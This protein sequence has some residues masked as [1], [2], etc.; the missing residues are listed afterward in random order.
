MAQELSD[1]IRAAAQAKGID[2]EVALRIASAESAM[3]A[4][5]QAGKSTAGGL[6]QVVDKTWKEFGGAPGK[7]YDAD[8]NIRVGTDI[9]AK[10]TQ[11]LKSFLQ[12]DPRPAEVYA[13]HYFGPTGAKNFLS[14]QPGTP[15]A[16][17]FSKEVIL[18]NPNLKGK[19]TDQVMAS[20]E[21]KMG[22]SPAP[23]AAPVVSRE[24][25]AEQT[26]AEKIMEPALRSGMSAQAPVT[27]DKMAGL[28]AGY[29]AALA[30]SFLA[31]T[32]EKEDRDIDREPG[33]AEKWLAEQPAPSTALADI[34]S[35]SIRS[36]FAAEP[37][38]QMLAEG[39]EAKSLMQRLIEGNREMQ[40]Y[41]RIPSTPMGAGLT[42][43]Y[44]TYKYVTGKDPLQDLQDQLSKRE[45]REI[46][47]GSEPMNQERKRE[48]L[49]PFGRADGG[50]VAHLALGG[51]PYVPTALPRPSVKKELEDI[52]SQ[53]D[54]YNTQAE[55]YN[56][57]LTKYQTE[58]MA[59]YNTQADLYNTGLTKYQTEVVAPYNAQ[60]EA[61][62]RAAEAYN[63]GPRTSEFTMAMPT[64]PA[65]Y[66]M[67]APITPADYSMAAPTAP[68]VSAADYE[69]KGLAARKDVSNRNL[70]L[71]VMADPEQ[72][73]LSINR[74]FAD[75]GEVEESTAS[76]MLKEVVPMDLR[77]LG[78]TLMG[79]KSPITESNFNQEELAAMQQAVDRAAA[80]TGQAQKGS[81]QYADYPKGE[82]IGPG[83]QPV[84]TTLGRF[85]YEKSPTGQTVI[86]DKY[87]FYNEGRK[88]N[89]EKYEKMGRAE[90]AMSVSG[91]MLKNL[92]TGNLRGVPGELADAYI[93]RD[94]REVKIRLPVGRA[95][96]GPAEPTPEEIEAASRPA[97]VNPNIQR[98]GEAARK[99]AAM[100]DVNTLPDPRTYA[101]VSG[102]LGT[103]PDEQGFSVMH[104]QREGIKQAGE[105]GFYTGTAL[106]VAPMMGALRAAGI[107]PSSAGKTTAAQQLGAVKM[108]GGTFG[109]SGQPDDASKLG[110]LMRELTSEAESARAPQE[111]QD[112][113]KT[114][115]PKYFSTTYGTADD[116]LRTAIRERRIEP[117]GRDQPKLTPYMIDAARNPEARGHLQAKL[118]LE[119]MY[120]EMSGVR[121]YALKSE[122][123]DVTE[124]GIRQNISEKMGQE[125]VPIEARNPSSVDTFS[126]EEFSSYPTSSRMLRQLVESQESLPPNIRQAL[127]TGE[128]IF[129]VDPS[130]ALLRP[131]NV[132]EALQEV[133]ANKLKNMSFPEA[134]IQG[135]QALAPI[136][137]YRAAVD[138]ADKGAVVPKKALEMFTTP[139]I[140]AP[141][142]KGEWV[143]LTKPVA[144]ELEGKLMKHS[145]GGYS[146]GSTYGTGYTALPFGGKKAFDEGLV[147]VYSLRDKQGMPSVTMELAKSDGGA[148]DKWNVTQ[149]RGRFNSE[150][151][152]QSREDIFRLLDKLDETQGLGKIKGNT[153][154]KTSTGEDISGP[155]KP[156]VD[157]AS[158]YDQWLTGAK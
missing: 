72:Y 129:D 88:A 116:P 143:R 66:S 61:Y 130:M 10:N 114:K 2:P 112:F 84:G 52:K 137:D 59:P 69:A 119:R 9:I 100:R 155:E 96:G 94:G 141:V 117:F 51:L 128:P 118:D 48:G 101:A 127:K 76:R 102:F 70:A 32:D 17:I 90:K 142:T 139:V 111:L 71:Q 77:I 30:L 149:I 46:D 97:T 6:F 120:D 8:E 92:V 122:G 150:P 78:S 131:N 40:R 33:I 146:E 21:K 105:A 135:T 83:Y 110:Y 38:P 74:M 108:R 85:V 121:A 19:T 55:L 49:P 67:A 62:N 13:A 68:T 44:E 132:I 41:P 24:T 95:D 107:G 53:Y 27:P 152:Y 60:S 87:D 91:N 148:G 154:F 136:R 138:L 151:T 124:R 47:T 20:L 89:V 39:G 106:Q 4:T 147:Q 34:S 145:I 54:T 115:A 12:R 63:A 11:T 45:G 140:A 31:D 125:G 73:G 64:A 144:T 23:K 50:E 56:K 7:K 104:P 29:Q 86:T 28:G 14:A 123:S 75:G 126:A 82:E 157:W 58:V 99:L 43:A 80:R 36:P 109:Y 3:K 1:K 5:A 25:P 153:Y 18:A 37:Q 15:M 26:P 16:D 35:T 134:L 57:G 65:D 79:N 158:E 133:P 93:G 42:A 98:Q 113:L 103:P 22:S 156:A 81:V